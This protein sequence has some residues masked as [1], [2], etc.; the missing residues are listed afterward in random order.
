MTVWRNRC[1]PVTTFSRRAFGGDADA[2]DTTVI[3]GF[4][5]NGS[6]VV[7][8]GLL[9]ILV[10]TGEQLAAALPLMVGVGVGVG[11]AALAVGTHNVSNPNDAESASLVASVLGFLSVAATSAILWVRLG[12]DAPARSIGGAFASSISPGFRSSW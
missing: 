12:H 8:A 2:M 9:G 1:V 6:G 7:V 11:V 5:F 4:V 10:R 3:W